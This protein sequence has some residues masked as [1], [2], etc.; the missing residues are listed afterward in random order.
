MDRLAVRRVLS[1]SLVS[2]PAGVLTG[3]AGQVPVPAGSIRSPRTHSKSHAFIIFPTMDG[4]VEDG[5][6]KMGSMSHSGLV[7]NGR[8]QLTCADWKVNINV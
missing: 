3:A 6:E 1:L 7:Q 5:L 4:D 8:I 2:T